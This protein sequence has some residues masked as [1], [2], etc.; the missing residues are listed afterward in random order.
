MPV[1]IY[2]W[3]G[4][5]SCVPACVCKT[6]LRQRPA[7]PAS[8][9]C[10]FRDSTMPVQPLSSPLR[11]CRLSSPTSP[12]WM[13]LSCRTSAP[14]AGAC[15]RGQTTHHAVAGRARERRGA[16]HEAALGATR[17]KH[18]GSHAAARSS[19]AHPPHKHERI[20]LWQTRCALG[21]SAAPTCWAG[22]VLRDAQARRTR[23]SAPRGQR[24]P[25]RL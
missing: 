14:S 3:S 25:C 1:E 23:R 19:R 21:A 22:Q 17:R 7:V 8:P 24:S 15:G 18:R 4:G 12:R 11:R 5:C 20:A 13:P 16:Q 2:G 6:P 9:A 10:C